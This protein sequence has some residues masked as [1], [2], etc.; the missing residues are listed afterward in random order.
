MTIATNPRDQQTLA[1]DRWTSY[2]PVRGR[3]AVYG[4][5]SEAEESISEDQAAC[6]AQ[7]GYS[8]RQLCLVDPEGYVRYAD[9][10]YLVWPHGRTHPALRVPP[11]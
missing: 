8:D 4:S 9:T 1:P 6:R 7:G 3:G 5:A 11:R 10:G 2:G